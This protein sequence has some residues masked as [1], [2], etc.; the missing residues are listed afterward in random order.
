MSGL[1]RRPLTDE[2]RIQLLTWQHSKHTS[3]YIRARLLLLA[4]GAPSSTAIAEALGVHV[5]T[6]RETLRRF[7]MDGLPGAEPKPRSGRPQVFGETAA[8]TLVVLLHDRPTQHGQNDARWTLGTIACALA[9]ELRVDAVSVGT[10]RRLLKRGRHS[11][12]RAKEWIESPD[13]RYAFKKSG[14]T[15]CWPG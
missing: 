11:W 12:Q 14:V 6:V 4:E 3:M 15:A 8:D 13:P 5:Q 1:L 9:Q 2:E 10:V 7:A